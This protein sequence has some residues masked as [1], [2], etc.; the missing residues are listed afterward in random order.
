M[1]FL[2]LVAEVLARPR[3]VVVQSDDLAPYTAPVPAFLE[4]LGEA[5]SVVDLHGRRGEGEALIERLKTDRPAVVFALGAKAAWTVHEGLPDTT[6]VY[7]SVL[8]PE[9]YGLSGSNV[10]GISAAVDPV[11]YLAQFVG[12][13]PDTRKVGLLRGP[14][15]S[16]TTLATLHLAARDAG[17]DLV[18]AEADSPRRVRSAYESLAQ[19]IDAV[20]LWPDRSIMSVESFRTL[21]QET[22]RRRVPLLVGTDNMVRA[23]GTF[24][25]VPDPAAVGVQAAELVRA[26]LAGAPRPESAAW[27]REVRVALNARALQAAEIEFEPLMLDFV[28]LVVR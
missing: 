4:A 10:L 24:A 28:D 27:P 15:T 1:L 12:F 18:V 14:G 6:L 13:F 2:T 16:D 7:A 8:E 11:G 17:V 26:V 19:D 21:T 5:A 20:W 9:R 22:R 3:V 23:G 25:V